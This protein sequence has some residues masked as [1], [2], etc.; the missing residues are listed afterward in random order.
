LR[1]IIT[2]NPSKK[3]SR[4]RSL[5][6][7]LSVLML[8]AVLLGSF[9]HHADELDHRDCAI[10]VVAHHHNAGAA[11]PYPV[12]L[13][14]PTSYPTLFIPIILAALVIRSIHSPRDRAPPA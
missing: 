9:H 11:A 5:A 14:L 13:H 7:F 8:V 12:T 1:T 2:H 10:C 6:L 3:D 4:V